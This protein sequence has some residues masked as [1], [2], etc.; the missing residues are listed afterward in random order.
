MIKIK[1]EKKLKKSKV[2]HSLKIFITIISK[3][4]LQNFKL[5]FKLTNPRCWDSLLSNTVPIKIINC[6]F[7]KKFFLPFLI[8]KRAHHSEKYV[9]AN[10]I[11]IFWILWMCKKLKNLLQLLK[12]KTLFTSLII[13]SQ[14]INNNFFYFNF[15][16]SQKFIFS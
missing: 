14:I 9:S 15:I 3:L 7:F 6:I 10:L 5:G 8:I 11:Q 16:T 2:P 12:S 1:L 13:I 4:N